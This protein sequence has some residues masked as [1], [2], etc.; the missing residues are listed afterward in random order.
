MPHSIQILHTGG[1]EVLNLTPIEVGESESGQARL[2]QA[3]ATSGSTIM[4][5]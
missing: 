5:S 2:R 3:R 1:P 4:T